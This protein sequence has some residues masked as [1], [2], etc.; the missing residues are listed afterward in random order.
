MIS[1]ATLL[2]ITLYSYA[3]GHTQKAENTDTTEVMSAD[4][5]EATGEDN[6]SMDT[7]ET[8]ENNTSTEEK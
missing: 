3:D 7:N 5:V 6:A 1:I 2:M 4:D 8:A